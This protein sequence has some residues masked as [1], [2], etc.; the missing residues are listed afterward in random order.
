MLFPCECREW[1]LS[2]AQK[3]PSPTALPYPTLFVI[4]VLSLQWLTGKTGLFNYKQ[5]LRLM[6]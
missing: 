2:V 4:T 5:I 6:Y 3:L 1:M